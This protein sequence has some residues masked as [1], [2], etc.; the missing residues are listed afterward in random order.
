MAKALSAL[1]FA[2]TVFVAALGDTVGE[3]LQSLRG[4]CK[5]RACL[6]LSSRSNK[7]LLLQDDA[8][9]HKAVGADPP[10]RLD[11]VV[12]RRSIEELAIAKGSNKLA[13]AAAK[14]AKVVQ[15]N[16]VADKAIVGATATWEKVRPL[17]AKARAMLLLIRKYN[18]EA[19]L[20]QKHAQEVLLGSRGISQAAASK[21]LEALR[22]WI[23]LDAAASA[24][25][26][27]KGGNN[28]VD[29]LAAAVAAAVEPY[30]LALLRNQ[31]FCAETYAKAK[32]AQKSSVKLIT[33]AK[34]VALKAQEMVS[35]GMGVDGQ[36]TW[37]IAA[38]MMNEAE[39]LRQWGNKLYG[40][41][42]A[43]C[44][45]AGGYEMLEQQAAANAAATTIINAPM[46]LPPN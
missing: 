4:P 2:A 39:L 6:L 25:A 36:Q 15:Q 29:R 7:L 40:E 24:E 13:G 41:A 14:E 34:P 17:S 8:H 10:L 22:G 9:Q 19:Q 31:K 16:F 37:G 3:E 28:K 5:R 35:S 20:H 33:D 12:M 45:S 44:G 32:S 21:A 30:H 38:G 18:S 1:L 23:K 27:N 11:R 46:A 42:N 26:S 43:A